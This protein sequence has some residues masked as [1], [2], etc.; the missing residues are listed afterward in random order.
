MNSAE[1]RENEANEARRL[2]IG[3][4]CPKC[5]RNTMKWRIGAAFPKEAIIEDMMLIEGNSLPVIHGEY[6]IGSSEEMLDLQF[7]DT[8]WSCKKCGFVLAKDDGSPIRTLDEAVRWLVGN[9]YFRHE[10]AEKNKLREDY[11][12]CLNSLFES[13]GYGALGP[14]DEALTLSCPECGHEEFVAQ[15]EALTF[16]PIR[17]VQGHLAWQYGE[18]S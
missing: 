9:R 1:I 3:F 14:D 17:I 6:R 18:Q 12:G 7:N 8:E 11:E 4:V 15:Q 5:T 2:W 13:E 16:T 10:G